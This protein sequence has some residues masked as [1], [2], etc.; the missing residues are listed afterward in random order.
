MPSSLGL[1]E[2]RR[3][4]AGALVEDLEAK[5]V[6]ARA[7]L[8]RRVVAVEELVAALAPQREAATAVEEPAGTASPGVKAPPKGAKVPLWREGLDPAVALATDYRH[9]LEAVEAAGAA[10]GGEPGLNVREL[11]VAVGLEPV[12]SRMENL[13][14][15]AKR[16]AERG[17]VA[18][19]ATGSRFMPRPRPAAR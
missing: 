12:V 18:M 5:L 19:D 9:L 15:K 13:R 7:V 14:S 3:D 1:L 6:A 10:G 17:W 16:L 8:E 11:A 2:M 4:A